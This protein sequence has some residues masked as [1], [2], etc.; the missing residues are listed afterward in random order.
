MN[1][2]PQC[3]YWTDEEKC[4]LKLNAHG[5]TSFELTEKF[6]KHFG[7]SLERSQIWSK[8]K[9]LGTSGN[10]VDARFV[11]GHKG[12]PRGV[13]YQHYFTKEQ[14]AFIKENATINNYSLAEKFNNKF[15]TK[16][17]ARKIYGMKHRHKIT[18]TQCGTLAQR[19]DVRPK[20]GVPS[21]GANPIGTERL[22]VNRKWL[23]P[24]IK[25]KHLD[26]QNKCWISKAQYVWE[27]VNGAVPTGHFIR[28]LDKNP[29]NNT[30]E[31]LE[32]VSLAENGVINRC[33]PF[34]TNI[35]VNK[36]NLIVAKL[37]LATSKK[38]KTKGDKS[39]GYIK[40]SH[41]N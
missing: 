35:E 25:V 15:G 28:H 4:W 1:K 10:G 38:L 41:K 7:L 29:L 30:I 11:K 22:D 16:L 23:R 36:S 31:N 14:K 17:N 26:K 27:Q 33:V 21:A 34:G 32:C 2:K 8:F 24:I 12:Y 18:G 40:L 9:K 5:I 20:R 19:F 37:I 3:H 39:N 13:G 6:N